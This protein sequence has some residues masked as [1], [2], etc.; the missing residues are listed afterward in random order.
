[1]FEMMAHHAFNSDDNF[2]YFKDKTVEICDRMMREAFGIPAEKLAYVEAD[3]KGG[4]NSG[5]CFEVMIEWYSL[6]DTWQELM[7]E[8]E[9]IFLELL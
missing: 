2:V 7:A 6:R 4:G 8:S 5:P 9:K 1:M 3:W